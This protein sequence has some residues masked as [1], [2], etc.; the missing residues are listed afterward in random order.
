M[1]SINFGYHDLSS[2]PPVIATLD[3]ETLSF[4]APEMWC[5]VRYLAIAVGSL[6]PRGDAI[7]LMYL[8][9]WQMLD[10]LFATEVLAGELD[11]LKALIA[12]YLE[13]LCSLFP[14]VQ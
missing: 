13:M 6:I 10:I 1:H 9:L 2:K 12:E 4:E 5:F 11:P 3:N 8:H 14:D 7:W